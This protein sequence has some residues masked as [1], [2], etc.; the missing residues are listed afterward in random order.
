MKTF[1]KILLIGVAVLMMIQPLSAAA[2][3]DGVIP[4]PAKY[5]NLFVY[6]ADRKF[7]GAKVEILYSNGDVVTTQTLYKRKMI[8][9]FCEMKRG[10]YTIRI[11]K[12]SRIQEYEYNKS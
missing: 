6:K 5:K 2:R 11:S 12:G 10:S 7:I 3:R 8:I 9:D 4:V 1:R